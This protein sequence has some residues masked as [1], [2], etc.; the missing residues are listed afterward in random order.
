MMKKILMILFLISC[1]Q[2]VMGKDKELRK[3]LSSYFSSIFSTNEPGGAVLL[4]KRGKVIFEGGYGLADIKT[5]EGISP[6]TLFNIGSISKTF[7]ANGIL[8]LH[9]EGKLSIDDSIVKYLSGFN[10]P[11]LAK[12]IRIVHLLSHTSGILDNRNPEQR[13]EFFLTAGDRENFEPLKKDLRVS[14]LPGEGF[15]Y[16]NPAY[17]ALALIIEEVTGAKWQDFIRNRVFIPSEMKRSTITEGAHPQTGV[18][19]GYIRAEGRF[20]ENDYGEVPTFCAAGNGGVWS[21]VRELLKYETALGEG[22]VISK[23]L[24]ERSRKAYKPDN[25]RREDAPSVGYGWFVNDE[26]PGSVGHTGSQ[27]GFISDY[28]FFPQ[29]GYFYVLLCNTPKPI[30]EIRQKVMELMIKHGFSTNRK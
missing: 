15:E 1:L 23:D 21:S 8:I 7:V 17:N 24:L 28:L 5:R 3:D 19:H 12:S 14:F 13:R 18:A 9:S 4:A 22:K 10:N 20:V 30:R 2:N 26:A 16:S 11:D 6:D 27:G 29:S 25:W